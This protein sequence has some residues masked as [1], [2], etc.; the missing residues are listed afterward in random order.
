MDLPTHTLRLDLTGRQIN[1]LYSVLYT[2]RFWN[3]AKGTVGSP[4]D[5]VASKFHAILGPLMDSPPLSTELVLKLSIAEIVILDV[6]L[7]RELQRARRDGRIDP[8]VHDEV[9][10]IRKML[11]AHCR[12]FGPPPEEAP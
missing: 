11:E 2:H 10:T 12:R 8:H 5:H 3:T 6:V 4:E 7:N 1:A 9:P